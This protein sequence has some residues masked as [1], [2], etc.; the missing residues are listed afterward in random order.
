MALLRLSII[1]CAFLLFFPQTV[2]RGQPS[3]PP[4]PPPSSDGASIDLG[5]AY[6]LM[7][8]AL[9]VTYLVHPVDTFPFNLF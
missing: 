7:F 8:V 1:A 5:V 3:M 2:V 6:T 4:S 9:L